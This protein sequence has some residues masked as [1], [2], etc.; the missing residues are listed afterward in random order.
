MLLNFTSLQR[1]ET[2][3]KTV[4][5]GTSE[6][7]VLRLESSTEQALTFPSNSPVGTVLSW[8]SKGKQPQ[9]GPSERQRLD[10]SELPSPALVRSHRP[11][12]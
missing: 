2:R 5:L 7:N 4:S 3:G 10:W 1:M 6:I 8:D 9:Q 11:G 12:S